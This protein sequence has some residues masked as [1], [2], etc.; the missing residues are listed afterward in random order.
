MASNA[1]WKSDVGFSDRLTTVRLI[2]AAYQRAVPSAGFSEAHAE[3]TKVENDAFSHA[4]SK[5][6]YQFECQRAI[7]EWDAMEQLAPPDVIENESAAASEGSKLDSDNVSGGRKIGA[8]ENA[9]YHQEGIFSTVYK[10]KSITGTTVALKVTTPHT[11]SPPH[12]SRREARILSSLSNPAI[13]PLL[14][15]F[16]H[17]GGQFVLVF[18]FMPLHFDEL[19]RRNALTSRQTRSHLRDLFRALSYIHSQGIIHRDV[20]PSN[21][22]LRELKG[23][24]YL[25]DFGIAWS[26]SDKASEDANKKITEVGTTCYRPPEVLFGD[27]AYG[28]SLDLWAAGCV[29]AEAVDM[30]HRQLFD[31]GELGSELALVHS[32]FVTLGTPNAKSWPLTKD[33]P[34]WGKIQFKE[35]PAK[36]WAEIL[37]GAPLNG[38]DLVSKLVRYESSERLSA[39]EALTHPYFTF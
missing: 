4:S 6:D 32:I 28:T 9:I 5:E 38:R 37:S 36:P 2:I 34:D 3:A 8:Y 30:N 20:K 18:P 14:D 12:D 31:A 22:L 17:P 33:L 35:Y 25:A 39:A 21:I 13:I 10:A 24:A 16:N 27:K 11:M 29:V 26:P 23:P 15:S 19:M 7:D 1:G